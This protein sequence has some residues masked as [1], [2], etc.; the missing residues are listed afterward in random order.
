MMFPIVTVPLG[1]D[2]LLGPPDYLRPEELR[3]VH[4]ELELTAWIRMIEASPW[5]AGH[6]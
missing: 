2:P 5:Y 6:P 1:V 3:G 4:I